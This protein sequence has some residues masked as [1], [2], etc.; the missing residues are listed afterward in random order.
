MLDLPCDATIPGA[1]GVKTWR[2][3]VARAIL[4]GAAK[5]NPAMVTQLL[6]RTDGKVTQPVSGI[7]GKDI[8]IRL[9]YDN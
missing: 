3:L 8:C 7:D 9:K 6:E 2:Q 5:G 4:Y 1:D